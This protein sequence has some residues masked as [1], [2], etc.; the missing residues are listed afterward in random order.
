[1]AK[2]K[3]VSKSVERKLGGTIATEGMLDPQVRLHQIEGFYH[4]CRH[5]GFARAVEALPYPITEPAL[6]QQVRKLERALGVRL[7]VQG[8]G[9]RM[10]PTP[11]GR[12]LF[13]FVASYFEQL[14]GLLRS[15][16]LGAGATIAVGVEPLYLEGFCAE[17]VEAFRREMPAVRVRIA[18]RDGVD[19]VAG[20]EAGRFDLG[21]ASQPAVLPAGVRFEA[22]GRLGLFVLVP[23]GHALSRLRSPILRHLAS[24]PC[25]LYEGGT[26]GRTFTDVVLR[27]LSIQLEV[28]AEASSALGMRSLVRAGVG[29]AFVPSLRRP[30]KRNRKRRTTAGVVEIDISELIEPVVDLPEFGLLT[31]ADRRRHPAIEPLAAH[32]RA[33][34]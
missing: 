23:E 34:L 8:P 6:H 7:L 12:T 28:A 20:L 11:E 4:V 24:H 9:R 27:E 3:S 29:A 14:P 1:M 10:I 2:K 19:I 30:S 32:L 21:I 18:E 5:R 26:M 22:F 31:R 15:V 16:G 13:D 25:I 17:A 33:L